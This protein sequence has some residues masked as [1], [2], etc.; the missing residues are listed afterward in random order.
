ML[1]SISPILLTLIPFAISN[2]LIKAPSNLN[3]SLLAFTHLEG[4]CVVTLKLYI[5]KFPDL[6]IKA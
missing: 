6:S 1:Y 3:L 5:C 2:Y 4:F